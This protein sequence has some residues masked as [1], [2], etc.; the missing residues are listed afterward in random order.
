MTQVG[1]AVIDQQEGTE[2]GGPR[3]TWALRSLCQPSRV[4]LIKVK[5]GSEKK[6]GTDAR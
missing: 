5:K 1:K 4:Q 2:A 3:M 6:Q